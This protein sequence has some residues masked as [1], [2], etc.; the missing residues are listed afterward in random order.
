MKPSNTLTATE[1]LARLKALVKRRKCGSKE[2]SNLCGV[3]QTTV[4]NWLSGKYPVPLATL[5]FLE[6]A[7]SRAA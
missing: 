1:R 7:Y 2:L 6:A 4:C 3:H 5:L